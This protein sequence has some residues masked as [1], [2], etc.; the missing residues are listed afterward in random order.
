[1]KILSRLFYVKSLFNDIPIHAF[2]VGNPSI[3]PIIFSMGITSID[4]SSY[5]KYAL[6][7]KYIHPLTLQVVELKQLDEKLPCEYRICETY[8]KSELVSM[9][10]TGKGLIALHNLYVYNRLANLF[11]EEEDDILKKLSKVNFLIEKAI[12]IFRI[13]KDGRVIS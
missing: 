8:S 1:M 13:V 9:L 11:K 5:L 7:M 2:G 10:G 3:L 6:N 4:S 12:K